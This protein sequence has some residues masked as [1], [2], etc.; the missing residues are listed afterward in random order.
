MIPARVRSNASWI[1]LFRLNPLDFD[2]VFQDAFT[3]S[4]KRWKE[5]LTF[6]F[7]NEDQNMI[8]ME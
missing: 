8:E 5:L 7:G 6:V 4:L 1:I 2:N 3:G